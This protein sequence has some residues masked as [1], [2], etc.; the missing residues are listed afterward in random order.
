[1]DPDRSPLARRLLCLCLLAL[2]IQLA[3]CAVP[4]RPDDRERIAASTFVVTGASSG[5]GRGVA[6]EFGAHGGN[7]VLAARRAELLEEVA[8][9]IRAAGGSALVVGTDVADLGDVQRLAEAA[10]RHFGR[11]D[12]W[13]NNAGVTAIGRFWEIPVEDHARLTDVNLKGMIYGSHAA[14]RQFH[15][16]GSG[17]LVN[18]G[19]LLSRVPLANQASYSA[20]KAAVL[21]LGHALHEELRLSGSHGDIQVA[22]V[23]PW[24]VDTPIWDHA[25]NYSGS[26]P[27]MVAMD[28]PQK[29]VDAIVRISLHPRREL[30]VGWKARGARL[31]HRIFPSLS[32]R[33]TANIYQSQ[34]D[35]APPAPATSGALHAPMP[36]TGTIGGGARERMEREDA[37]ER[38]QR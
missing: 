29:V 8:E 7:V 12:V 22:T 32:E 6:L 4:L 24:A 27:R 3:G 35:Q 13:I 37:G 20:S 16:Q 28:D 1:M 15:V 23:L 31:G 10:V 34:I 11:I 36:H 14:L 17:T 19:S 38:K 25:A 21:S 30:P 26:T 2:I 33:I 9:K 5:L 18:I